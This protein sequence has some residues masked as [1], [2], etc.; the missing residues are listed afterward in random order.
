MSKTNATSSGSERPSA[1]PRTA[2][3]FPRSHDHRRPAGARSAPGDRSPA[4]SRC[5]RKR[6][7]T[8]APGRTKTPSPVRTAW[9]TG[10][11]LESGAPPRGRGGH[12]DSRQAVERGVTLPHHQRAGGRADRVGPVL[13]QEVR[14]LRNVARSRARRSPA[15]ANRSTEPPPRPASVGVSGR[16][17]RLQRLVQS[18]V[19]VETAAEPRPRSRTGR[20]SRRSVVVPL[21]T[22]RARRISS[23]SSITARRPAIR[24]N[25]SDRRIR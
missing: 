2:G 23:S 20:R 16:V 4:G 6:S 11:A 1:L 7:W 3:W 15:G 18:G 22:C 13:Q 12:A 17:G 21:P 9:V 5:S 8:E 19:R 14:R 10:T 25:A 24:R